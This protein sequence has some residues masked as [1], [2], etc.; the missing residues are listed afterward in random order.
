[1]VLALRHVR[2]ARAVDEAR[3]VETIGAAP[4]PGGELRVAEPADAAHLLPMMVDFNA[5]EGIFVGERAL[6]PA[7]DHLL[8]TPALGRVWFILGPT[9][10]RDDVVGY[11]VLTV[12]YDLEFAGHDGY[13]TE[14]Y[15]RPDARGAGRGRAA[16]AAIEGAARALSIRAIH[17]MVRHENQVARALY[18]S[19]GYRSPPRLFLSKRLGT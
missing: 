3:V 12:G 19:A 2:V 6:G 15:L 4:S 9:R 16:L 18:E 5:G 10:R 14:I 1:V 8:R 13:L 7:L 17:L 11:A